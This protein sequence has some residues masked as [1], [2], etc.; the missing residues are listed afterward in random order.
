[1]EHTEAENIYIVRTFLT[2]RR[3]QLVDC[4][5][6]N[7]ENNLMDKLET[8]SKINI[9]IVREIN[10]LIKANTSDSNVIPEEPE[11]VNGCGA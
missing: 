5:E 4:L 8:N 3:P 2:L 6:R 1:M 10:E 7:I 9:Q 11:D